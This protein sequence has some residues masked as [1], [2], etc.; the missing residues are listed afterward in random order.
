MRIHVCACVH[1]QRGSVCVQDALDKARLEGQTT[2][3]GKDAFNLHTDSTRPPM[4]AF[5]AVKVGQ[6]QAASLSESAELPRLTVA[7]SRLLVR[8]WSCQ[9]ACCRRLW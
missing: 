7:V 9:T 8:T 4:Q 5:S 1:L 2:V 3:G 6:A